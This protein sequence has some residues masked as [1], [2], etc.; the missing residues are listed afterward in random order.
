MRK[1]LFIFASFA[2]CFV[3]FACSKVSGNPKEDADKMCDELIEV[4][5]DNNVEKAD[6]IIDK[7]L[8][9]YED[10]PLKE[11][12]KFIQSFQDNDK[13]FENEDFIKMTE[14][15]SFRNSEAVKNMDTFF[16]KTMKEALREGIQD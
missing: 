15:E 5:A 11:R 7:Y 2:M 3:L 1:Y 4:A 12:V 6:K 10:A 8:K 14:K 16:T 9:Y 13:L